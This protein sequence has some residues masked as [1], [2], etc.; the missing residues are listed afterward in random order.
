M[1]SYGQQQHIAILLQLDTHNRSRFS[2][3]SPVQTSIQC[4]TVYLYN[5]IERMDLCSSHLVFNT[6][7]YA[8]IALL[9]CRVL[10][11]NVYIDVLFVGIC[12]N[13]SRYY[14]KWTA[15]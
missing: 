14:S 13:W 11:C 15:L 1:K 9:I 5:L 2:I 12:S 8:L 3:V 10:P 7:I 6:E 4:L